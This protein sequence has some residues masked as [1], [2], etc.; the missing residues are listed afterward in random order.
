MSELVYLAGQGFRLSF[1]LHNGER[2]HEGRRIQPRFR[3]ELLE[4][5]CAGLQC[6]NDG[7][8]FRG[9]SGDFF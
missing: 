1:D 9:G 2:A 3:E 5:Q 8:F 6:H 4:T 7:C